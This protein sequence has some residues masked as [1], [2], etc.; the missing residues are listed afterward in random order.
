MITPSSEKNEE[1]IIKKPELNIFSFDEENLLQEIEANK[2][3]LVEDIDEED[4]FTNKRKPKIDEVSDGS[5][6][7]EPSLDNFESEKLV[8]L[9][10]IETKKK[11][12]TEIKKKKVK[13][14]SKKSIILR[15]K[16]KCLSDSKNKISIITNIEV[17]IN[18]NNNNN[19]QN[20]NLINNNN[21]NSTTKGQINNNTNIINLNITN[22]RPFNFKKPLNSTVYY[23]SNPI[24]NYP[25]N[26]YNVIVSTTPNIIKEEK[27]RTSS[28][29]NFENETRTKILN[30]YSRKRDAETQTEDIFFKM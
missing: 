24:T 10:P 21:F 30:V 17:N 27:S 25:S 23:K 11:P 26:N 29:N 7:D 18:Q 16:E 6:S 19:I 8:E 28:S 9:L 20:N 14:E 5:D 4:D 15:E 12:A 1:I 2:E 13:K 3:E 22:P